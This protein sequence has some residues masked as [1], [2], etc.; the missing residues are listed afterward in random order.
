MYLSKHQRFEKTDSISNCLNELVRDLNKKK[1]SIRGNF[2]RNEI[3]LNMPESPVNSKTRKNY[4]GV[5]LEKIIHTQIFDKKYS[6][7]MGS[8]SLS[9]KRQSMETPHQ[10]NVNLWNLKLNKDS[11]FGKDHSLKRLDNFRLNM[12][13]SKKVVI[14]EVIQ[15]LSKVILLIFSNLL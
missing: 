3:N 12:M 6:K 9:P 11:F 7:L 15:I 8:L 13:N 1:S 5:S 2:E 14:S 10:K 4:E